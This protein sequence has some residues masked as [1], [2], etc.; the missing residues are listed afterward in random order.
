MVLGIA[1][2]FGSAIGKHAPKL[3]AL[4]V[5]EGDDAVEGQALKGPLKPKTIVCIILSATSRILLRT[6]TLHLAIRAEDAAIPRLRPHHPHPQ[7]MPHF[8]PILGI[9]GQV[10][11]LLNISGQGYTYFS[12]M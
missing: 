7:P 9:A 2:I 4:F 1:A 12:S 11:R 5:K 8:V 10:L 6:G 3:D